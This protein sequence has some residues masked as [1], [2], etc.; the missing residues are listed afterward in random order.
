MNAL[1][2]RP[3]LARNLLWIVL[4]IVLICYAFPF[5]YLI[6]TSFK[7]PLNAISVSPAVWPRTWTLINYRTA[8]GTQGVPAAL[9]NSVVTAVISTVLSLALAV[10]AAYGVIRYST[11]SG[12]VFVMFAL[13]VRMIPPVAIGVPLVS[14]MAFLHLTDTSFGL[15]LAQTTISLP[16]SIWLMASFFEAV[17][18]DLEEAARVD[19]CGRLRALRRVVLPVVAGGIAVT[20]IFAFLA[21]WNEF[22]FALLLTATRA[23]TTPIAIANFQTQY[24]L[25]WGSM[26]A[27]ATLYS[28]PVVVLALLLQR[29]IVAGL[30]LGAVK[31]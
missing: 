12:R 16:L 25:Q 14:I 2:L 11:L 26:T 19:G 17:P 21:S 1:T 24:G 9:I 7:T 27:L 4:L 18:P 3:G 29:R 6:L 10:P 23:G 5:A 22:L 8:L 20:A 31:G 13:V 30:T 28:I 15:A